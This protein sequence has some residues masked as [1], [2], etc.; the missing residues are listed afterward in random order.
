MED[1]SGDDHVSA[2]RT[3]A[4]PVALD[5]VDQ[6]VVS[7]LIVRASENGWTARVKR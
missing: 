2:L 1:H 3:D 5:D 4:A 6:E 7:E